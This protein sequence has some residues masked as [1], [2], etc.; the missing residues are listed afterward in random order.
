MRR[1]YGEQKNLTVENKNSHECKWVHLKTYGGL[2]IKC[3]RIF[4]RP[5]QELYI[6]RERERGGV[7][8]VHTKH[9]VFF[10]YYYHSVESFTR[11]GYTNVHRQKMPMFLLLSLIRL[12]F[13]HYHHPWAYVQLYSSLQEKKKGWLL[14]KKSNRFGTHLTSYH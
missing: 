1:W 12:L 4:C 13:C 2:C 14:K 6:E 8:F 10:Y 5:Q 11:H 7:I 3:A 9:T